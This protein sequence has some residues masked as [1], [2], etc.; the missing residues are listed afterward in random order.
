MRVQ[1]V[2]LDG[3]EPV[4]ITKDLVLVGRKEDCDIFLT[5]KSV[6]KMHCVLVKTEGLLL[7]RDLGST[8]GTR[9]NG[10]R[11]RRAAILPNDQLQVASL[12]FRVEFTAKKPV[13][14]RPDEHTQCLDANEVAKLLTQAKNGEIDIH[15]DSAPELDLPLIQNNSLP[16]VYSESKP[17]KAPPVA[18]PS[19]PSRR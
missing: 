5:H 12:R 4:E 8:N 15:S 19:R 3:G 16:D 14:V 10:Q 1:L 2:P 9:V 7:L 11:V 18:D 6:S 13:R 17:Q